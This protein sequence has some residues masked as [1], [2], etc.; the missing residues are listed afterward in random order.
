MKDTHFIHSLFNPVQPVRS[1]AES[2]AMNYREYSPVSSLKP[3]VFC[4]WELQSKDAIPTEEYTYSIVADGCVDIIFP[5]YSFEEAMLSVSGTKA[6]RFSFCGSTY[7]FGIRF[8]PATIHYFFDLSLDRLSAVTAPVDAFI[9][10]GF[11]ELY[12]II[13]KTIKIEEKIKLVE[14]FLFAKLSQ[15]NIVPDHRFLQSLHHIF[16]SSG[17]ASINSEVSEYISPRQ[18]QRMFYHYL[19]ISPKDFSKIIRFQ[20]S[21]SALIQVPPRHRKSVFYTFGYYDQSH[22][23]RDFKQLY[24]DTPKNLFFKDE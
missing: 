21:L 20:K 15:K 7:Y 12:E 18:Q 16:T 22:F 17:N 8:F 23:I 1:V 14:T 13:F 11:K 3:Y 4:F 9:K 10:D 19:G 5:C 2:A 24:G 6:D